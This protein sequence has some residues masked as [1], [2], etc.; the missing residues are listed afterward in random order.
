MGGTMSVADGDIIRGVLS[1]TQFGGDDFKNVF[2]WKVDKVSVGTWTD[3]AVA[4][5]VTAAI[6]T[7]FA[8]LL[9]VI[10]I[11]TVFDLVDLYKYNAGE[12]DWLAADVPTISTSSNSEVYASGVAMLLTAHTAVNRVYGRKYIYGVTEA[13]VDSGTFSAACLSAMADAALE[14]ITNYN[15]GTMGAL[16]YLIPGVYSSKAAGFV[17]FGNIAVV[18]NTPSY[19]RRRKKGVG[20]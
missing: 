17:P 6:E 13:L 12:W 10:R 14:Y 5:F 16:D 11:S 19:Q 2:T 18:K 20:I 9:T 8:E 7:I 4:G 3:A 15:G 1:G